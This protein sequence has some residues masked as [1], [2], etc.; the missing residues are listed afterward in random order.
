MLAS[1]RCPACRAPGQF[2]ESGWACRGCKR[3]YETLNG[4]VDFRLSD[5]GEEAGFAH[6]GR[7]SE[8]TALQRLL[9]QPGSRLPELIDAYLDLFQMN[10]R[11]R[12]TEHLALQSSPAW[13]NG[14][15]H[16]AAYYTSTDHPKM[17][18]ATALD[19]GCSVGG[20]VRRLGQAGYSVA[21]VDVDVQRLAIANHFLAEEPPL[22]ARAS[23]FAAEGEHLPFTASMFDLVVCVEVLEHVT[24]PR[25]VLQEIYRVL[26]PGG[27]AFVTTPNRFALGKEPHVGLRGVGFLP[28][29]LMDPYVRMR[30]GIPYRRKRNLS[31]GE[32]TRLFG[33]VFGRANFRIVPTSA[34]STTVYS[35]LVTAL[36]HRARTRSAASRLLNSF[37]IVARKQ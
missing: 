32:V 23:L 16:D 37:R 28:R 34:P 22:S 9:R 19:L 6:G 11:I 25:A 3:T 24:Q 35:R 20:M 14:W 18:G 7:N 36:W 15:F 12:Q 2:S 8:A 13:A 27:W 5:D 31:Y 17:P 29:S 1:L 26:R 33:E 21:G 4:L 10:P 30:L